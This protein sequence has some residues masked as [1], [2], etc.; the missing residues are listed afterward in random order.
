MNRIEPPSAASSVRRSSVSQSAAERE[1]H[2]LTR[3]QD[4]FLAAIL[5]EHDTE[6]ARVDEALAR[7]LTQR[8][9]AQALAEKR[10]RE[11][12]ELR[13]EASR[14]RAQLGTHRATPPAELERA[15]DSPD[16]V[17]TAEVFPRETTR[18]GVGP[19]P[20]EPLP[21]PSFGPPPSA[22]TPT[23]PV[24]ESSQAGRPVVISAASLPPGLPSPAL[25]QKPDPATR[26]LI[27]YSLG[28]NG[29]L[30]ETLEGA[31]LSSKPPRK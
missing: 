21:S 18:P 19:K 24:P 22:W 30:S 5:E 28:G 13:A 15:V 26:P 25:K 17:S 7:A 1:R 10:A 16:P 8:D 20:S 2:I 23:P 9:E 31:R 3:Q 6:Y 14:L 12:D 29:V 27:D 11:R 4:D